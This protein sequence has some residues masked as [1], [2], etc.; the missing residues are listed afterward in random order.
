MMAM[1]SGGTPRNNSSRIKTDLEDDRMKPAHSRLIFAAGLSNRLQGRA[2][3]FSARSVGSAETPRA[4]DLRLYS[5]RCG[6]WQ[7]TG[8][9]GHGTGTHTGTVSVTTSAT[10]RYVVTW[11]LRVR[12]SGLHS[13]NRTV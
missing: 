5:G 11:T 9:G 1:A 2:M 7:H 8:A 3:T 10:V 13:I 12:T 4:E 6:Y